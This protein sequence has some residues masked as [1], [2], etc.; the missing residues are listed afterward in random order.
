MP[1]SPGTRLG[2]YE[3]LSPL[4][5][6]GMGEV[7][8][9]RDTRLDRLV[10]VK[11]LP[12][13]LAGSAAARSRFEREAKAVAALSHPN[14]LALYDVGAEQGV[15]F[16]VTELLEGETLRKRLERGARPWRDVVAIGAAVADGLAAAH[17]KGVIHRDLKPDNIFLTSDGRV[18]I[19]DFGLARVKPRSCGEQSSAPTAT[20]AG[21]VMGT[22][23]YMSP[24]QVRGETADAPSDLF[25]LGCVLF[26]MLA[27]RRPFA[28]ETAAQTMAAIL[29]VD[30]PELAADLPAELRRLV[31]HCL[32]KAPARRFQSA[33][34][35]AFALRA[36]DDSAAPA[37]PRRRL[38]WIAPAAAALLALG[39]YFYWRGAPG[40][41]VD[42]LAVLPFVNAG[43][44]GAQEVLSDGIAENLTNTLSQL[45]RLRVVARSL[46]FRHRGPNV[47]PQKAGRDL[48]VRAVLTGR[49]AERDG[50][51]NVQAELM[52][53]G[54][55]AQ[56]WGGQ[57]SRTFSEILAL[58]R[59]IADAV[60]ARLNLK[61]TAEQKQRLAKRST[62][63]PEAF[64][65]YINGRYHWNLRNE[66]ALRRAVGYFQKAI[67]RDPA[68]ALAWAG[69]ADCYA[70]FNSYQVE[71]PRESGPKAAAAAAKALEIDD[72]LAQAHASQAM[73]RMAYDWDWPGAEREF[74][75]AIDLDPDYATAHHWFAVLLL[76]L[77]RHE[78]ALASLKRA[79]QLDPLS[80]II[81]SD[82][83]MALHL[84]RR[85]DEAIAQFRKAL[86]M[87]PYFVAGHR[88]L[89]AAYREKGMYAEAIAEF[90]KAVEVSPGQPFALGWLGHAY[91][92]AGRRERAR[93]VIAE[94]AAL[95]GRRYV[96]PFGTALVYLGLGD[97]GRTFEWLE[98]AFNDR[99]LDM[100][101]MKSDPRFDGLRSDPRFADLLRRMKLP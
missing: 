34:D 14:I 25:S 32:E 7:Y 8:S 5:A 81:S 50:L 55:G 101:F 27:A 29:D 69:L 95:A 60:A 93:Q 74:R 43:G 94:L 62:A 31:N 90:E 88:P 12:E 59:E 44:G 97:T 53:V 91:A 22:V 64:Q 70:L 86:E 18:K 21:T 1:L 26:E 51:L 89:G 24:E 85:N 41:A 37:R 28:R 10:A 13:H 46:A 57:Y 36:C 15:Y 66:A 30:P 68:Y 40:Q 67:D 4:G 76:A 3:I 79:Q 16:V 9:A 100:I 82:I 99:A 78:E 83:G 72:T 52:N 54:D 20:E 71:P 23:G 38:T 42:S 65:F 2:P 56:L 80:I 47:D 48:N 39:T 58:Q 17:A 87:A 73:S 6:G 19:L 45:P 92:V 33:H 75:R 49:V 11:V 98:K 77:G 35:L 61:P 63:N 84:A 96:P